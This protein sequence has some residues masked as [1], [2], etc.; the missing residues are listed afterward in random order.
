MNYRREDDYEPYEIECPHCGEK[1][2]EDSLFNGMCKE[3]QLDELEAQR[4]EF[5]KVVDDLF[6]IDESSFLVGYLEYAYSSI[7]TID[8]LTDTT[9]CL[10]NRLKKL[11]K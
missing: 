1:V 3:C 4:E 5:K 10:R 2:W 9:A 6:K 7:A 8:E 11:T